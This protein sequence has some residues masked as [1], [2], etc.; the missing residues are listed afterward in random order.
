MHEGMRNYRELFVALVVKKGHQ[1]SATKWSLRIA[2]VGMRK[3]AVVTIKHWSVVLERLC[4]T[5]AGVSG[6]GGY[7]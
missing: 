5:K 7:A 4:D 1:S 3:D 6:T 2:M